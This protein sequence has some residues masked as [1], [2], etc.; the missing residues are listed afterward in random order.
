MKRVRDGV[1]EFKVL[2]EGGGSLKLRSFKEVCKISNAKMNKINPLRLGFIVISILFSTGL[3]SG[4]VNDNDGLQAEVRDWENLQA[5]VKDLERGVIIYKKAERDMAVA[6]L[7]ELSRKYYQNGRYREAIGCLKKILLINPEDKEARRCLFQIERGEELPEESKKVPEVREEIREYYIQGKKYYHQQ[8]YQQAIAEF[9]KVLEL[10]PNYTKALGY[11]ER[12]KKR[13]KETKERELKAKEAELKARQEAEERARKE[14]QAKKQKQAREH[15][16][17]GESLYRQK[18]Y[19]QAIAEFQK[20]LELNPNYTKAL[21]YIERAKKRIKE[22]KERE[23][24][25]KEAELK[26]RQEA[27]VEKKADQTSQLEAARRLKERKL[28]YHYN[29]GLSYDRSGQYKKAVSEYKKALEVAPDDADTHYNLAIIYDDCL[30]D[31]KKAIEHYRRYL[32]LRPDA[33]DAERV[34]EW[35][36]EAEE[37]I[38]WGE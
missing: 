16:L 22:T 7:Y 11:I 6:Y 12:A 20:V 18:S 9:Q 14:A 13:I 8:Q 15:Y 10:N 3:C 2:L 24:K 35:I 26:A 33:K 29:L 38:E 28:A 4:A 23:L 37:E 34:A 32:Q 36:R 21:G 5:R 1:N 19:E 27:E 25:A 30:K 31:K 17:R